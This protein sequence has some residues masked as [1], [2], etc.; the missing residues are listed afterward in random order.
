MPKVN[1]EDYTGDNY[2]PYAKERIKRRS[3]ITK[4]DGRRKI[5][6]HERA[7]K[8]FQNTQK[9]IK[10]AMSGKEKY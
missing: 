8:S 1:I 5:N 9:G 4:A 6:E 10:K 3:N 2:N 7:L